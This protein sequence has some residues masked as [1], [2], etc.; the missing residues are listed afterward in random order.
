MARTG[1]KA[2]A[3]VLVSCR[4]KPGVSKERE[5]ITA[6]TNEFVDV[7]VTD[8]AVNDSANKGLLTIIA[9][10]V[11]MPKTDLTLMQGEHSREKVV[12]ISIRTR[13]SKEEKVAFVRSVLLGNIMDTKDPKP[14]TPST[15]GHKLPKTIKDD[16]E[17]HR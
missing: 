12:A 8:R 9:R 6:V 4:V 5:G 17:A 3:R 15:D 11:G 13:G 16:Y 2:T 7:N 1:S 14:F 10:A